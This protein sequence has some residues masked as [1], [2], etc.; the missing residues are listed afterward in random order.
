MPA[1][2]IVILVSCVIPTL[3]TTSIVFAKKVFM[4]ALMMS[5]HGS[6]VIS[7][8]ESCHLAW[9]SRRGYALT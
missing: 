7:W 3:D 2:I 4:L 9:L 6:W 5:T 1:T 8:V